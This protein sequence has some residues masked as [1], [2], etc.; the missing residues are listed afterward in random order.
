MIEAEWL[1]STDA[2][3][4]LAHLYPAPIGP[5]GEIAPA[6]STRKVDLLA[7]AC[8]RLHWDGL[9]EGLRDRIA[10]IER[11]ADDAGAP[12]VD[13]EDME[14]E[15]GAAYRLVPEAMHGTLDTIGDYLFFMWNSDPEEWSEDQTNEAARREEWARQ[16]PLVRDIFGDPFR[17]V[18]V[19][20]AWR[21]GPIL[22]LATAI[23]EERDFA[24]LPE[25]ADALASVGCS[26]S[27]ILTHCRS[28]CDHVRGC[29]VLDGLLGRA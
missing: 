14:D 12:E 5:G 25:L 7:V 13:G 23:Y 15:F 26:D 27:A 11:H 21:S 8:C 24:R 18:A 17:P 22:A 20:P 6:V 2:R 28:N 10:R 9:P 3:R 19:D 1:E 4:M 29:W 16:A